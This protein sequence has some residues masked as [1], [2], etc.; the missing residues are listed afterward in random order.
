MCKRSFHFLLGNKPCFDHRL[1]STF[2]SYVPMTVCGGHTFP[3]LWLSWPWSEDMT[4]KTPFSC[5]IATVAWKSKSGPRT[6]SS[7][8]DTFVETKVGM[9]IDSVDLVL[10]ID[11]DIHQLDIMTE[12]DC[13]IRNNHIDFIDSFLL[14]LFNCLG[15][16]TCDLTYG[17]WQEWGSRTYHLGIFL[18]PSIK[19]YHHNLPCHLWHLGDI[20]HSSNDPPSFPSVGFS[21]FQTDSGD[22]R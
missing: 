1:N 9:H 18:F 19:L 16:S 12:V 7:A 17:I 13:S 20:P 10:M 2:I 8:F 21:Q 4:A 15:I 14:E 6:W 11:V 5:N 22:Q 3:W